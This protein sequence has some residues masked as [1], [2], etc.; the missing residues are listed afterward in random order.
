M[1]NMIWVKYCVYYLQWMIMY[2]SL[3]SDYSEYRREFEGEDFSVGLIFG[4]IGFRFM[5]TFNTF[6][7]VSLWVRHYNFLGF[8]VFLLV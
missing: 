4:F 3:V 8:N 7:K 1:S 6:E 5:T 2:L